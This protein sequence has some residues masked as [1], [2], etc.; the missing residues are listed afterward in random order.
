MTLPNTET[1]LLRYRN[2]LRFEQ[3]L[4]ENSIQ[5]YLN[6]ATK[7]AT[8]SQDNHKAL[9]KLE[10]QDL[11]TFIASLLDLDISMRSIARIISGIKSF[12]R[13]LELENLVPSDPTELLEGPKINRHLPDVLSLE[14][15]DSILGCIDL[16]KPEGRRNTAIVE[17]LY[18]CGLRVSELCNLK[19][20]D[21]FLKEGFIR[22]WGKGRKERLVP[23]SNKAVRDINAYLA[24]PNRKAPLPAYEGY[25]FISSR[26]KNIS[27]IMVFVIV[28]ELTEQAGITK[29]VS[30]HT[31]RHSFATHLLE[32]GA[33]LHSIQLMLGHQDIS[34]TEIYTHIDRSR[35]R[36][37]VLMHHPRNT[38]LPKEDIPD[39]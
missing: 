26:R 8:Y 36:Q 3:N 27:R 31:F 24:D 1:L 13:F 6:D 12:Y 34:T 19:L 4:S 38:T 30:P 20:N 16:D 28:K 39:L 18:S 7:L 15:I 23:I 29:D 32:G 9:D 35:L 2:Y 11:N 33:D 37:Q 17:V 22:I 14:E 5:A 25:L 21:L 10:L